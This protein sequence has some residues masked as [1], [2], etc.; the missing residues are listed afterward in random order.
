MDGRGGLP[1]PP[2]KACCGHF[3]RDPHGSDASPSE[4][5][6]GAKLTYI[7]PERNSVQALLNIQELKIDG[8]KLK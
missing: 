2:K 8:T 6:R 3:Q 7:V 4:K 5:P 1:H